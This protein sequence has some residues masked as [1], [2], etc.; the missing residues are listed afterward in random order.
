MRRFGGKEGERMG[1]RRRNGCLLALL[2]V[3]LAASGCGAKEEGQRHDGA[4]AQQ[5]AGTQQP[6]EQGRNGLAGNRPN[7]AGDDLQSRKD[8]ELVLT[9]VAL[10]QMDKQPELALTPAEA[11]SLLPIVKAGKEKGG[12]SPEDEQAVV[13]TLTED[14]AR[15]VA[16]FR[17]RAGEQRKK[18]KELTQSERIAMIERFKQKRKQEDSGAKADGAGAETSRESA[19]GGESGDAGARDGERTVEQQLLDL[20]EARLGGNTANLQH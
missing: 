15:F 7:A 20:L 14:Q 17:E 13:R 18:L 12:L 19:A 9:F 8:K 1:E 2:A 5:E 4:A 11:A 6:A 10:L 3:V 16:E